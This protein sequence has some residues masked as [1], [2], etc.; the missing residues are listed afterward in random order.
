MPSSRLAA[1]LLAA[2]VALLPLAGETRSALAAGF[3]HGTLTPRQD[4]ILSGVLSETRQLVRESATPVSVF[5]LDAT[6]FD[7]GGRHKQIMA[8]YA[9]SHKDRFP[10]MLAK[11]LAW[12]TDRLPYEVSE[13]FDELG[14]QDPADRKDA[15]DF[16]YKRFFSNDY[17][18]Y[19]TPIAGAAAFVKA[20]DRAGSVIVYLTGRNDAQLRSGTLRVLEANG[21]PVD[22][23]KH[24]LVMNPSKAMR[25]SAFKGSAAVRTQIEALGKVVALFDNEPGNVNELQRSFPDALTVFLDTNHSP[26]APQVDAGIPWIKNF[27]WSWLTGP[28]AAR[29]R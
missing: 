12:E 7:A 15:K 13:T 27:R 10:G 28:L 24:A 9:R 4:A 6:L 26:K 19:D 14:I 23:A 22:P 16:W 5:D 20:L 11:V 25:D 29:P 21:F 17:L 8:E 1:S 3:D 2:G 18:H